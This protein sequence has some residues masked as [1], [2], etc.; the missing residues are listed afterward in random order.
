MGMIDVR[1]GEARF[2]MRAVGVAIADEHVLLHRM[3]DLDYWILPGGRVEIGESSSEAVAREM[4]EE[5]GQEV[6]VERLL[7]IAESYLKD[8]L[9]MTQ[10]L[11]FYY[12]ISF[13]A[14]S[15]FAIE[16]KSFT[17]L[18]GSARLHFAWLPLSQLDRLTI[19]P[20]FLRQ[21]LRALPDHPTRIIDDRR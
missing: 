14:S 18:D 2:V 17:T 7:W 1:I 21:H 8:G 4:R 10:S 3:D 5:L 12:A 9:Q 19:F 16:R 15:Q 13:P 6:T 20:P 11:G